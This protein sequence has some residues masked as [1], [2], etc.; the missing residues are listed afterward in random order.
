MN[1][2]MFQL[3]VKFLNEAF[4]HFQNNFFW[5]FQSEMFWYFWIDLFSTFPS[6]H[7]FSILT[8]CFSSGQKQILKYPWSKKFQFWTR[9]ASDNEPH[10]KLFKMLWISKKLWFRF[11][12]WLK[13][14]NFLFY[15]NYKGKLANV[16]KSP[17]QHIESFCSRVICQNWK[18]II[19]F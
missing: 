15:P 14:Q 1:A 2:E 10:V 5:H 12:L 19:H 13:G 17:L 11:E 7:C 3:D 9:S 18:Y 4:R 16:F 8:F 6:V